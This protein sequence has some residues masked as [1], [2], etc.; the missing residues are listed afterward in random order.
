MYNQQQIG[1]GT[2]E[3]IT[4]QADYTNP[5]TDKS[6]IE[7]GARV[8]IRNVY[9]TNDIGIVEPDGTVVPQPLLSSNYSYHDRVLAGYLTYSNAIKDFGYQ[10]GLRMESSDY[11]GESTYA[12]SDNG[13]QAKDTIGNFSNSYPIEL[14]PSVFLTQKLGGQQELQLN[15]TRR[16]DRPSFFQLF[17]YTDYSDSLNLSRGNP[18]LK[19]TVH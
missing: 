13:G 11:H 1:S 2:N 16:I 7:A 18:N 5:I 10:L 9:S 17:P 15:Y 3:Y 6:K 8:A 19:T 4:A 14:F 12:V